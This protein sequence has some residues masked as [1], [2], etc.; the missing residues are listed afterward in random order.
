LNQKKKKRGWGISSSKMQNKKRAKREGTTGPCG[1]PW[2]L[3]KGS[4]NVTQYHKE[5][6]RHKTAGKTNNIWKIKR[7]FPSLF[8]VETGGWRYRNKYKL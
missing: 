5:R 1:S 4:T 2:G 3:K 8:W 7:N 6:W